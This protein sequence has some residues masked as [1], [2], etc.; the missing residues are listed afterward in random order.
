MTALTSTASSSS[1]LRIEAAAAK[2]IFGR[3]TAVVGFFCA[4]AVVV[5]FSGFTRVS[6]LGFASSLGLTDMAALRLGI[7]GVLLLPVLLHYGLAGVAWRDALALAFTGGL[8]FALFAFA[9]FALAPAHGASIVAVI[10][11]CVYLPLSWVLPGNGVA[12]VP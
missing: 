9:G 7:G 12:F 2:G 10:S 11:M 5:L 3:P 4:V 8:G 1:D 6:K